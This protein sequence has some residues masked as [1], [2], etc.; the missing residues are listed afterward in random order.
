MRESQG[1]VRQQAFLPL[2][3]GGGVPLY[4]VRPRKLARAIDIQDYLPFGVE[5]VEFDLMTVTECHYVRCWTCE[6]WFFRYHVKM[7][8]HHDIFKASIRDLHIC[9][10][11]ELCCLHHS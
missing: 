10:E 3:F 2:D 7:P 4:R 9:R 6:E 5:P 8:S 1:P 11:P